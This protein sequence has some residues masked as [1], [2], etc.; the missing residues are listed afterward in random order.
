MSQRG[1]FDLLPGKLAVA[2][3]APDAAVP[4][5]AH[6]GLFSVVTRTADELSLVCPEDGVPADVTAERG[7]RALKLRG[8]IPFETI[9]VL[10]T[11][12]VTLAEAHVSLFA[13]STFDTDYVLV[14]QRD[15]ARARAALN[16]AGYL[17]EDESES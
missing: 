4:A 16:G 11:M 3:L 6:G 8:P 17:V 2:R 15:L 9:G 7:W 10:A 13:V 5:W 14:K 1:V 12:A